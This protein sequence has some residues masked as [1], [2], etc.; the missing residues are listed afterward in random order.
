MSNVTFN[1]D[2]PCTNAELISKI[3]DYIADNYTD[4]DITITLNSKTVIFTFIQNRCGDIYGSVEISIGVL[5]KKYYEEIAE[6]MVEG[7]Y[8]EVV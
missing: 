5:I 2:I 6:K 7:I 3:K 1:V 8:V 4:S